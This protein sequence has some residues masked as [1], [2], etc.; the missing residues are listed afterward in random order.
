[1]A[2]HHPGLLQDQRQLW[3]TSFH[4]MNQE[5][6]LAADLRGRAQMKR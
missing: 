5:K 4:L 2:E 1:M 6:T 3:K